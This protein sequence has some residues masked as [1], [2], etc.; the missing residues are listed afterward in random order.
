MARSFPVSRIGADRPARK[1]GGRSSARDMIDDHPERRPRV[2]FVAFHPRRKGTRRDICQHT[3]QHPA[4]SEQNGKEHPYPT[5]P[6]SHRGQFYPEALPARGWSWTV[7]NLLSCF[8]DL[9]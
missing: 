9:L 1:P 2:S 7:K 5:Q 6:T 3:D 4:E 8:Q